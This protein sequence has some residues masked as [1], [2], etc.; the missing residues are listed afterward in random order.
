MIPTHSAS[1][2][3]AAT[4]AARKR[5][6]KRRTTA[7]AAAAPTIGTADPAAMTMTADAETGAAAPLPAPSPASGTVAADAVSKI[8]AVSET[9][10]ETVFA[11]APAAAKKPKGTARGP[12]LFELRY[13]DISCNSAV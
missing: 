6:T 10:P 13:L 9:D 11:A 5:T 7:A 3:D 4:T 2:A 12:P 1:A 8:T